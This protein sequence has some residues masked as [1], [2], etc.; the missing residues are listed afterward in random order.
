MALEWL[1]MMGAAY[2]EELDALDTSRIVA[3]RVTEREDAARA[4]SAN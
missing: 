1:R 3:E 4:A 2:T